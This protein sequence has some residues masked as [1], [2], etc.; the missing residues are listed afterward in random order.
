MEGCNS[1]S[2]TVVICQELGTDNDISNGSGTG[3]GIFSVITTV[4]SIDSGTAN[5]H[6]FQSTEHIT[7]VHKNS[8]ARYTASIR[9]RRGVLWYQ[10]LG[11]LWRAIIFVRGGMKLHNLHASPTL[12]TS[13]QIRP[14]KRQREP[15][16][17]TVAISVLVL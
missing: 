15:E 2:S 7:T 8:D 1:T 14:Q 6:G 13:A 4:V 11:N 10:P 5:D 9:E 12:T 3:A 16:P 17:A